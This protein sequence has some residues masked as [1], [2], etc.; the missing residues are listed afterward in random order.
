MQTTRSSSTAEKILLLVALALVWVLWSGVY[1]P[2]IV[3]L[4]AFS[5]LLTLYLVQRM[6]YFQREAYALS[7]GFDLIGYW[8]WLA[9]EMV[10]ST[11][12]VTRVI[13]DPRMPMSPQVVEIRATADH[14]MDQTILGNS[15]TFTPGTLTL[16]VHLGV[17]KVHCLTREGAES[18]LTGEMDRRVAAL[19]RH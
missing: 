11:L 2:L 3:S 10:I 17:L 12:Q 6:G 13:L 19:R 16:D 9:R 7:Y 5:C 4:G 8:I 14:P 15:I 1:K 18:L